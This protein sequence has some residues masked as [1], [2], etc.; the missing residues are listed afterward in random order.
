MKK[1]ERDHEEHMQRMF[2]GC[3]QQTTHPTAWEVPCLL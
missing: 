3:M 1:L 2:M